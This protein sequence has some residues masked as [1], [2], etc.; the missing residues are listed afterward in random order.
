[1]ARRRPPTKLKRSRLTDN[2]ITEIARGVMRTLL[3]KLEGS[4][5]DLRSW[6]NLARSLGIKLFGY[7][8]EPGDPPGYYDGSGEVPCIF[9]NLS[10]PKLLRMFYIIHELAHHVLVAWPGSA[11]P[12]AALERYD[13]DRKSVQHRVACR[14]E[15]LVQEHIETKIR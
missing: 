6:V 15:D 5:D 7:Y 3:S 2:E 11:F 14:V 1:M 10:A 12:R 9:Y 4:P 13:D 8:G